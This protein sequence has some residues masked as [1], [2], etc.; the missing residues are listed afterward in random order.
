[1]FKTQLIFSKSAFSSTSRSSSLVVMHSQVS[2]RCAFSIAF[3]FA[4]LTAHEG[5]G[6]TGDVALQL[7][8]SGTGD[9]LQKMSPPSRP[10]PQLKMTK[11]GPQKGAGAGLR[12]VNLAGAGLRMGLR[13]AGDHP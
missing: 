3:Q 8:A 2:S 10:Q 7:R 11:S 13:L 1:M 6:I 4:A 9:R 12:P 5:R